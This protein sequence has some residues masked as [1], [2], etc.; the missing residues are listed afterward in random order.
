MH[1]REHG[2]EALNCILLGALIGYIEFLA[3]TETTYGEATAL[4]RH[5]RRHVPMSRK[6]NWLKIGA[7]GLCF[8]NATAYALE[9]DDIYYVEGYAIDADLPAPVQHAWLVNAV[10]EVVA[11]T[12]DDSRDHV[13]FGIAFERAFVAEVLANNRNEPAILSNMKQLRRQF[14]GGIEDAVSRAVVSFDAV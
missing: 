3:S 10:G 14:R 13:Y 6:P 11:P 12:W 5:G 8:N 1:D 9:R 4:L 2:P 7:A